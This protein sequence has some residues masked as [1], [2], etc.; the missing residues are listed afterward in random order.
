M[1]Q[2]TTDAEKEIWE[3]RGA[4]P[5]NKDFWCNHMGLLVAPSSLV[6]LLIHEA[7]GGRY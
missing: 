4:Q 5:D 7:Q 2:E 1:Q 3:K 6:P